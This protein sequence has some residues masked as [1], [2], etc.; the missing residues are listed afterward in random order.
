MRNDRLTHGYSRRGSSRRRFLA[1]TGGTLVGVTALGSA[2][3]TDDSHAE[4]FRFGGRVQG[5][6]GR[7]P[8]AIEGETNPTLRLHTGEVYRV[9][10]TNLDGQPH[11]FALRNSDG[12]NLKVIF[13]N[14]RTNMNGGNMDDETMDEGN[15]GGGGGGNATPPNDAIR[16]TEIVR[17]EGATQTFRFVATADIDRYTCT[18]HPTT[19]QGSVETGGDGESGGES[20]DHGRNGGH[21]GDGDHMGGNG[22]HM[23]GNSD[24]MNGNDDHGGDHVGSNTEH[25]R[26]DRNGANGA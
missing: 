24:H 19:M 1:V 5:W 21:N 20:G 8:N 18:V 22:D 25:G 3:R 15:M 4:A 16:Q 2:Q 6:Q 26:D 9:T 11:N 23:N 10:W 14:V 12:R 17:T 7:E 13:P